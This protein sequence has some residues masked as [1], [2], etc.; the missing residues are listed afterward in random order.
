MGEMGEIQEIESDAR[1]MELKRKGNEQ[2]RR[3][4]K[5]KFDKLV[6]WR[7]KP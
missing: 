1:R 2:K 7:D 4:K 3:T 6:G 5:I